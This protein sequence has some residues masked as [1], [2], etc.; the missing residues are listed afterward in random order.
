[1]RKML[2]IVVL[3]PAVVGVMSPAPFA[4]TSAL[5]AAGQNPCFPGSE[6]ILRY[7]NRNGC[8]VI[9]FQF[10]GE[11]SDNETFIVGQDYRIWHI[12]KVDPTWRLRGGGACK[13]APNGAYQIPSGVATIQY[14]AKYP[15]G[16]C[17]KRVLSSAGTWSSWQLASAADCEISTPRQ[18]C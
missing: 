4:E 12:T 6:R 10:F 15:K 13:T 3:V 17:T 2:L 14:H 7:G 5:A 11:E 16:T 8:K 1:M 9:G 18:R